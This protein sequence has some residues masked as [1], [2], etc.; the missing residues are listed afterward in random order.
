M[1]NGD[2]VLVSDRYLK[3]DMGVE[4]YD[5]VYIKTYID[6]EEFV[7]IIKKR[8]GRMRGSIMSVNEMEKNDYESNRQMFII[9]N[10]FSV[11]ALI[12]GIFGI[13][14]IGLV[15]VGVILCVT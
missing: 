10:G 15:D 6:P 11:L 12:I 14:I 1:N 5:T 3:L 8:F 13:L 7:K 9:L 2:F 4:F